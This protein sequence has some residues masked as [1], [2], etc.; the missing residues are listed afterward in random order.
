MDNDKPEQN[1]QREGWTHTYTDKSKYPTIKDR[2][3]DMRKHPT[4]AEDKLWD[5][6]R[7]KR[8]GGYKFRRQH[9]IGGF[10]ADFYCLSARLVVEVDGSIHDEPAQ[11]DYDA[12]REKILTALGLRV[13]RFTNAQVIRETDAVVERLGEILG[14]ESS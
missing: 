14:D 12:D 13:V 10:I 7:N 1:N 8:L 5:R 3:R 6:L 11:V 2:A 9:P 4:S